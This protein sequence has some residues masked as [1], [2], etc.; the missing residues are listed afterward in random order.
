M[1][2]RVVEIRVEYTSA[3]AFETAKQVEVADMGLKTPVKSLTPKTDHSF[4][5]ETMIKLQHSRSII[6]FCNA[7]N[8]DTLFFFNI[9]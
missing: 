1:T 7:R 9:C 2:S 4:E 3:S 8:G 6:N 5:S